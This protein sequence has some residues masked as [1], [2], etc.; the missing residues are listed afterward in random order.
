MLLQTSREE[1]MDANLEL[2]RRGLALFTFGNVSGISRKDRQ[3]AYYGQA[4][5]YGDVLLTLI[6]I[7][8]TEP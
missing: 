8:R 7:A 6:Q 4:N 3:G 2:V 5:N 1:V